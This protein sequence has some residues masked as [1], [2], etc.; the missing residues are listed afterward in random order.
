M[1]TSL[2]LWQLIKY[3]PSLY[4]LNIFF[5]IGIYISP[6]FLGLL[7]RDVFN[8]MSDNSNANAYVVIALFGA[9][10]IGRIT[11]IYLGIFV[12]SRHTFFVGNLVRRNLFDIIIHLPGSQG[13]K[14]SPG[15]AV[16]HIRDDVEQIVSAISWIVDTIGMVL[17]AII[18][19]VVLFNID[20]TI[21]L[22][23]FIP[24]VIIL[25]A[26]HLTT[27]RIQKYRRESREATSK[28]AGAINELFSMIQSV[29]VANAEKRFVE[30][31]D[32]LADRQK[33][34]MIKDNL[35]NSVLDAFFSNTV[36]I[37]MGVILL[38]IAFSVQSQTL[39]V[40]DFA[41]FNFYLAFMTQFIQF[42]GRFLAKYKQ[43]QVAMERM[44][45]ILPELDYEKVV[46]HHPLFMSEKAPLLFDDPYKDIE[47]LESLQIKDLSFSY[48]TSNKGIENINTEFR[49]G[50]FTVIAGRVGSGK[51]TLMK[52]IIGI[53]PQKSGSLLWNSFEIDNSSAFFVPPRSG[54]TAQVPQL[55]NDTLRDNILL[56]MSE[57]DRDLELSLAIESALLKEDILRLESGLD[58]FIGTG[59]G[60]LSGGQKMRTAAARMFVRNPA[61]LFMDDI[62][63][64][65]DVETEKKLWDRVKEREN[66]T[67]IVISNKLEAMKHAD[68]IIVMKDGKI[69]SQGSFNDI[70]SS[71]KELNALLHLDLQ[72]VN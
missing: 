62:S 2:F 49:K 54:Y 24:L 33:T 46:K 60:K 63:S 50:S 67:V 29:K 55:Y 12:D 64:A 6:V 40:G 30:R 32:K 69:E 38:I 3:K 48:D 27:S 61:L 7:T 31:L 16:N 20:P 23:V 21:T 66:T 56:G 71:S 5:W 28:I 1:K 68:K 14:C 51:S 10:I 44:T 26:T 18:S 37:G 42:F 53:L 17:F 4:L 41:L 22:C 19:L 52:T 58:T 11:F 70:L 59:G 25:S 36:S 8:I 35:F 15:E 45:A 47:E 65:L 43:T 39:S 34:A 9:A 57:R 13:L 72:K